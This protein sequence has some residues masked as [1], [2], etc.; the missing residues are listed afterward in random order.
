MTV[1]PCPV[2]MGDCNADGVV[3]SA[4]IIWYVNYLFKSGPEPL[5]MRTVGDVNCSG[6]LGGSDIIFMVNYFFKSG[7]A[8][9]GCYLRII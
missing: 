4:D 8:P 7:P 1:V 9:C 2:R 3:N 6:G 5:P